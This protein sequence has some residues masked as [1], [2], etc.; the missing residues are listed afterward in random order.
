MTHNSKLE[1]F[2]I[3]EGGK[4]NFFLIQWKSD[5]NLDDLLKFLL[6]NGL[7]VRDCRNFANLPRNCFRIAIR[8]AEDN[9]KLLEVLRNV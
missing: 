2:K 8:T 6:Q 5:Q 4:A 3:L 7:C 1:K 9:D